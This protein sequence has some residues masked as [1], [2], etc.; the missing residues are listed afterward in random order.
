MQRAFLFSR[1]DNGNTF[2][3]EKVFFGDRGGFYRREVII[4]TTLHRGTRNISICII[5][6]NQSSIFF[7]EVLSFEEDNPYLIS[8]FIHFKRFLQKTHCSIF[9]NF[10]YIFI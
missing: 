5:L 8:D 6:W 7:V 10:I 9:D 3:N 2:C 1:K 4:L